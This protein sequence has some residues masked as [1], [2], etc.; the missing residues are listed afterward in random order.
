MNEDTRVFRKR[1]NFLG[2]VSSVSKNVIH[3]S[4]INRGALFIKK[5]N[6]T[7]DENT[8]VTRPMMVIIVFVNVYC[9]L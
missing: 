7:R 6:T 9:M 1:R 2:R 4:Y 3:M 8:S 5:N